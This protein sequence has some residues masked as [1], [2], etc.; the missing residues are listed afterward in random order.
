[1]HPLLRLYEDVLANDAEVSLPAL[2]R[3]IFVVHGSV[4]IAPTASCC[5]TM[6]LGAVRA[7][8]RSRPEAA[9]R[10]YGGGSSSRGV[11]TPA[12]SPRPGAVSREKLSAQLETLPGG[13]LLLRG[14][15]VAFPAGRL[16]LSAPA[17][18]TGHPLPDRG[19]HPH[20]H[21]RPL[22]F[23]RA[24]RRLVRERAGSGLRPSRRPSVAVYPRHDLAAGLSGKK[25]GR[26]SQRGRQGEAE[27]AAIQD[28]RRSR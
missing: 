4:A 24:R 12:L 26:I 18:G 8:S 13:A 14:D 2:P 16:R 25:L 3:M 23:L 11:P 22:V 9:A 10:R 15:S 21:P 7:R 28:L 17:S 19:R 1:M 6:R 5:T 20:R 27:D